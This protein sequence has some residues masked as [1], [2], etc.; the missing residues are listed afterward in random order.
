MSSENKNLIISTII[1]I[2]MFFVLIVGA[3]YAYFSVGITSD[4]A[5][6]KVNTSA[7][8]VGLSTLKTGNN[9][10]L[11]LTLVDM[12]KKESDVAYYATVEGDPSTMEHV[13]IIGTAEVNG[14]GIMNC[15]YELEVNHSGT[16]NMLNAFNEMAGKSI[17]QL[18]L[19]ID[20][21]DYDLFNNSFPIV[22]SGNLNGVEEGNP[23]NIMASFKIV[24]R[25]DIDQSALSGTDIKLSFTVNDFDC[26]LVG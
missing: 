15:T 13:E 25:S 22:V 9:L 4:N 2:I 20:N 18:I 16:N 8:S 14:N 7:E 19:N 26:E 11:N 3:T 24:N 6:T 23:Q 10:N 12:M 1:V 5:A 21:T 17:N